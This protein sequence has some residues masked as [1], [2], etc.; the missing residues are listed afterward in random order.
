MGLNQV[1]DFRP[2]GIGILQQMELAARSL[3]FGFESFQRIGTRSL[4]AD[5]ISLW[6]GM[7]D[8]RPVAGGNGLADPIQKC[9]A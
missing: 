6:K 1:K 4:I 8:A 7:D 2:G 9:F 5:A 3:P